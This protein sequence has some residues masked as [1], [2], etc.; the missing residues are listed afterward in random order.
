MFVYKQE[1]Y[2]VH[3]TGIDYWTLKQELSRGVR[4]P[5]PSFCPPDI[6]GIM[7][8]CWME[9]PNS[10]PLFVELG[11]MLYANKHLP[12]NVNGVNETVGGDEQRTEKCEIGDENKVFYSKILNAQGLFDQ[13]KTI[14]DCNSRSY[15]KME[16]H[17]LK[18]VN[19]GSALLEGNEEK[20]TA[21]PK[22]NNSQNNVEKDN[23]NHPAIPH[24][25]SCECH[26][27]AE[28]GGY[29]A[30]RKKVECT[31]HHMV[32]RGSDTSS[33]LFCDQDTDDAYF[34]MSDISTS[35]DIDDMP[36]ETMEVGIHRQLESLGEMQI[37]I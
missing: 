2:F 12:K 31:N 13:Y 11:K 8:S 35:P 33:S 18:V 23:G 22:N 27:S 17:N 7:K 36:D 6:A 26:D 3:Y 30:L 19:V 1:L 9:D 21:S 10:R 5:T 37:K 34:P 14:K 16:P 32:A 20:C 24:R 28:K 4:L 25:R 15:V 29:F